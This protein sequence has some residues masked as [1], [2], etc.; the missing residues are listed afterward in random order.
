MAL[1]PSIQVL[2]KLIN[3]Y[4]RFTP[5]FTRLGYVARG[6][7]M[8]PVRGDFS[9][10]TWLVTGATGGLGRAAALEGARKGARV[11]AVG[12]NREELGRLVTAAGGGAGSMIAIPCDLSSMAQV[13]ALSE[14]QQLAGV[15]VDV[16]INNVGVLQRSFSTT[17]EGFETSYATNL[18]G[19]FILT[20]RLHDT[21]HLARGAAIINVVSGG[22]YNAPLNTTML[23]FPNATFNG[24]AAYGSHKRA[25]LALADHWRGEFGEL[26]VRTYAVHPGWADTAGVKTSLP[27]FRRVLAPILRSP[28]QGVDTVIWL[29]ANRPTE[30]I[31]QVWFDR[32]PRSAHAYPHTRKALASISDLLARLERDRE[33]V[34]TGARAPAPLPIA[35]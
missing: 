5:S 24:F 1:P 7:P 19:H 15:R 4:A 8:R 22:L 31:D 3:F 33:S 21:G 32:K 25:Q 18:L 16:L 27:K 10:Q 11:L 13:S 12:R 29:A 26:G 34:S 35:V 28:R 9:G 30:A 23:D 6:L 14:A 20:E 17:A 2:V